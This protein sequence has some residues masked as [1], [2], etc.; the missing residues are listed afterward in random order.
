[1]KFKFAH[2]KILEHRKRLEN[3]AQ[4]DFM[5]AQAALQDLEQQLKQ[6]HSAIQESRQRAYFLAVEGGLRSEEL[7][8]IHDFIKGTEFKIKRQQELIRKALQLVEIRHETLRNAA[9]EH[10]IIDKL[11]ENQLSAFKKTQRKLDIKRTDDL[12]MMRFKKETKG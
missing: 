6:L 3:Q 11:R 1:M 9:V 8:Q 10:K 12:T 2:Q 7:R 5:Q 4:L